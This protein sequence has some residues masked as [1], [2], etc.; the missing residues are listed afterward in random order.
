MRSPGRS[1]FAVV[2]GFIV[3]G[4]LAYSASMLMQR[5][6]P[7]QFDAVGGTQDPTLLLISMGYVAVFAIAGCYLAARLAP[8]RPMAHAIALGVLGLVFNIVGTIATWN[9]AP[10]WYHITSLLLVMP[11]AWI[12]GWL[13]E[14]DVARGAAAR[15]ASA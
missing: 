3:I 5:A 9:T 11:Y 14:R 4:A 10:A 1:A 2:T 15:P 13:R 8:E 12:G 7:D 6:W